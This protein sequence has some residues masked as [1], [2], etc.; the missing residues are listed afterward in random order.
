MALNASPAAVS[1]F[2]CS[3][4]RTCTGLIPL[5]FCNFVVPRA[6]RA[7]VKLKSR[8]LPNVERPSLMPKYVFQNQRFESAGLISRYK[9]AA[10]MN[11]CSSFVWWA[12]GVTALGIGQHGGFHWGIGAKRGTNLKNVPVVPVVPLVPRYVP[13]FWLGCQCRA[14]YAVAA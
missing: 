6:L 7:D 8:Q 2:S 10:L 11:A 5:A 1:A 13:R 14:L 4:W 3:I 12:S 9:P